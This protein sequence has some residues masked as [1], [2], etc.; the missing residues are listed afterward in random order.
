LERQD[1]YERDNG[2][3]GYKA[4]GARIPR[5]V[6]FVYDGFPVNDRPSDGPLRGPQPII[7]CGRNGRSFDAQKNSQPNDLCFR[8]YN[9]KS[10]E[11]D[12]EGSCEFMIMNDRL[13]LR[14]LSD[15][16][17]TQ[18]DDALKSGGVVVVNHGDSFSMPVKPGKTFTFGVK[19]RITGDK[20]RQI[21]FE[22]GK[23]RS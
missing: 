6:E 3:R 11:L 17:L 4:S 1:R 7:R 21:R 20:V 16:P 10:G 22:L 8:I 5:N 12:V 15:R 9:S 2:Y 19:F 13:Y 18:N 14:V 23:P